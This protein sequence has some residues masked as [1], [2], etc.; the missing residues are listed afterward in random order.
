VAV[1]CLPLPK[2]G[3]VPVENKLL[4]SLWVPMRL[5]GLNEMLDAASRSYRVSP[6]GERH[7]QRSGYT[8]L[9]R[10]WGNR[11]K[12]F[13]RTQGVPRIECGYFTYLLVEPDR[14][15]DPSNVAAGA[16]KLV[17]DALQGADVLENDGWRQIRG[18]AV[19][20]AKGTKAGVWVGITARDVLSYE[21]ALDLSRERRKAS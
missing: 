12:L 9:K 15:R 17:E 5:P 16:V 11:I 13:V 19:Y 2:R 1:V 18:Y 10:D 20:W 6:R 8:D 7:R 21:Q 3:L 14:K 4:G